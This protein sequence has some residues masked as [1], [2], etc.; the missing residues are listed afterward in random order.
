[1]RR[2]ILFH[3]LPP[4]M[5]GIQVD[6]VLI[7]SFNLQPITMKVVVL[8]VGLMIGQCHDRL[9]QTEVKQSLSVL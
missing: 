4:F 8:V 6:G 5:G 7:S 2:I 3:S 1:M 9:V